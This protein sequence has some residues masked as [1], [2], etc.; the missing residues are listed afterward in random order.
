M[1]KLTFS[2]NGGECRNPTL[3]EVWSRHSHSRKW[4]LGVPRD[5][6]KFRTWLQGSKHL[7]LKC[8]LYYWKGLEVWMSKMALHEPFGH[9]QHKLW[10]K[11]GP[12]VKLP[13]WLLTTKS[14]KSTRSWC[15]QVKCDPILESSQGELQLCFKPHLNRRSKWEVTNAQNLGSPNWDSFETPLWESW[16]KMP[17]ECR[18][19]G[20]SQ[21]I[22]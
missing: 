14:W 11:E 17:F 1:K 21:R 4:D 22:L 16:E 12:G 5:S 13:V 2:S 8:S 6:W 10:S 15:V 18:C 7:T 20:E 9:S 3:R 19:N